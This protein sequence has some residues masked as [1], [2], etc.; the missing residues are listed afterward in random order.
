MD[1][2]IGQI[3]VKLIAD[4]GI[5]GAS[6]IIAFILAVFYG[7][8][9]LFKYL[10]STIKTKFETRSKI[11]LKDHQFFKD[12]KFL[13]NHK[14]NEVKTSCIIRK[15]LYIDIMRIRILCIQKVFND[16][17]KDD[18]NKLTSKELYH[19]ILTALDNA[20]TDA[21][22]GSVVQGVPIFVLDSMSEKRKMITQFYYDAIKGFCYNNYLY[23]NNNERMHAILELIGVYIECYMNVLQTNLAEFNG[24][25]KNLTY[26]GISC[27]SCSTCIHEQYLAELKQE[28]K[29]DMKNQRS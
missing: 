4:Y 24:N 19:T 7:F 25:I 3:F 20:N 9:N 21:I 8:I 27:A 23:S 5:F 22:T 11:K 18:L 28:I 12:L 26:K 16:L 10:S 14:L 6:F 1:G 15:A 13:M 17:I 29:Q 2:G